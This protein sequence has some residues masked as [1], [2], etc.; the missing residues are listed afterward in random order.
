MNR[1]YQGRVSS[2]QIPKPGMK[3][4]W[5]S[6]NPNPELASQKAEDALRA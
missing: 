2:V 1:I 3:N 6:L 4:E 5:E